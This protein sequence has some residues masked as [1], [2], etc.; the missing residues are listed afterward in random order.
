MPLHAR[1]ALADDDLVQRLFR[2]AGCERWSVSLA[3]FA[4]ALEAS[5]E[6]AVS[7]NP[8]D[9]VSVERHLRG[10]HLEDLALTCACAAGNDAAWEHFMREYRPGLYRAADA[11]EPGGGARELADSLYAEL[12]GLD[13]RGGQRRS[14][15]AYYHG[16]SGLATWLRAVL[17]QRYVDRIRARKRLEPLPDEQPAVESRSPDPDRRRHLALVE[18]ALQ[19][20]VD[21]LPV[22]DRLRLCSYYAEELTL[23]QTGRLLNEHEA[24]VS[25]QLARTRRVIR[26]HVEARLR[27][28]GLSGRE[29]AECFQSAAEDGGQ[30]DLVVLLTSAAER[31]PDASSARHRAERPSAERKDSSSDR[32]Y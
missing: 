26:E 25:R 28:A 15:F 6:R 9:R 30:L 10:L 12:Y 21:R 18:R 4:A 8:A 1:R 20:A 19:D 11:L 14:L 23:A 32:S 7:A 22:R 17:A 31:A 13:E 5:V 2:Q 16:R 27:E 3:Q 24:T 29:I